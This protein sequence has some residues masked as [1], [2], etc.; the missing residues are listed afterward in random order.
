MEGRH[1]IALTAD[2][3]AA[4]RQ[5]EL[6]RLAEAEAVARGI[7]ERVHPLIRNGKVVTDPETG[8]VVTDR[9]PNLKAEKAIEKIARSRAR[10]LGTD[11]PAVHRLTVPAGTPP[12]EARRLAVEH[13][14]REQA[15]A[16]ME[17]SDGEEG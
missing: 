16:S 8:D 14:L 1:D 9:R 2:E 11:P 6:D 7:A 4:Y 17:D 5:D 12:E 15:F 10:L 3:I 13:A